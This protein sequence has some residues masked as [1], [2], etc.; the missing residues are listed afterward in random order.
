MIKLKYTVSIIA[1]LLFV[2]SCKKETETATEVPPAP[3]EAIHTAEPETSANTKSFITA[4]IAK[5]KEIQTNLANLSRDEANALYEKYKKDNDSSIA[6]ISGYEKNI[7]ENYYDYFR[8]ESGNVAN[9]PDSIT[10]KIKLLES[11]GLEYWE[12][13]EGI[14]EIRTIPNF[15]NTLFKDHVSPDYKDYIALLAK[16]DEDLYAADAGIAI[17]FADVGKRA[18]NWEKFIAK[19]P[20]SKLT[21][22]AIEFYKMYQDG[23]LL[24]MDNTPTREDNSN[25]IYPENLKEFKTFIEL[26][27]KSPT[28]TLIKIMIEA[29]STDDKI[30][31]IIQKEQEKLINKLIA[32][33]KPDYY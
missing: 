27:P 28:S 19:H 1:L 17:S 24:G 25:I 4:F 7:L 12:I 20:Y 8:N 10:Q 33:T 15:Y 3:E 32:D 21:L 16:D 26:H 29:Q 13:G 22:Q 2:T 23:F 18:I 11:A 30:Y 5:K 14:V 9:P 6:I 31:S